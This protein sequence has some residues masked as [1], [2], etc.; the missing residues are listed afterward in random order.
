[1][2]LTMVGASCNRKEMILEKI[3]RIR[4]AI[5]IGKLNTRI[6]LN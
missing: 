3:E 4:K 5:D 2:L 1:M 6:G